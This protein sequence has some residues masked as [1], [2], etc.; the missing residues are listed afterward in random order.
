MAL[1]NTVQH[2]KV[3]REAKQRNSG[4]RRL[5]KYNQ[6]QQSPAQQGTTIPELV[7]ELHFV[8]ELDHATL[9]IG[10]AAHVQDQD[11]GQAQ[12]LDLLLGRHRDAAVTRLVVC[13]PQHGHVASSTI[14]AQKSC[15]FTCAGQKSRRVGTAFQLST[16]A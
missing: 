4:Q 10:E 15:N 3:Q 12:Q 5:T 13:A 2:S 9:S 7:G 1:S 16:Q 6:A 8:V 14:C 11:L